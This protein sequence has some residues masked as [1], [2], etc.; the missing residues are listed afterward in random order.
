MGWRS[1][2]TRVPGFRIRAPF[3]LFPGALCA[4]TAGLL[5]WLSRRPR[6]IVGDSQFAIGTRAIAWREVREI[7]SSRLVSPL[8]L[9]LKLTNNRQKLM[10]YPGEPERIGKLLYQLRKNAS[11]ATFDGVSYKDYWTWSSMGMTK[12]QHPA[13]EQPVKMVSQDDE[14]EIERMFRQLKSV[15]HLES[16]SDQENERK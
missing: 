1:W 12:G 10:V 6:I 8:L 14:D 9:R 16:R 3:A 11:L 7:N 4:V 13:A 15:G 2:R 5:F